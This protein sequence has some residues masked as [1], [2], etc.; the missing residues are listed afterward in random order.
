MHAMWNLSRPYELISVS[1][2]HHQSIFTTV[3]ARTSLSVRWHANENKVI[4]SLHHITQECIHISH[5][6]RQIDT[7]SVP[8][9][10]WMFYWVVEWVNFQILEHLLQLQ[11]FLYHSKL[12]CR[13]VKFIAIA[14]LLVNIL[15][16][17]IEIVA[18]MNFDSKNLRFHSSDQFELI[19]FHQSLSSYLQIKM[20]SNRIAK[21]CAFFIF[22]YAILCALAMEYMHWL[23][24]I[25][26][27]V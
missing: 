25:S 5:I 15:S 18:Y 16:I 20:K 13:F 3:T 26:I 9:K 11:N 4:W 21:A 10:I 6:Q 24:G 2:F 7:W 14:N 12:C 22:R 8:H 27:Y 17:S 19:Q 1:L 23:C